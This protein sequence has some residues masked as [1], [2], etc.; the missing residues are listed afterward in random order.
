[1]GLSI[2]ER[3]VARVRSCANAHLHRRLV[4]RLTP[5]QRERLDGLV[6]VPD[7]TRQSPLDRLRD[8]P[9][10]QSGAEIGRA[11]ARLDEIRALTAGLPQVDR[12][13]PGKVA[14]L[15]S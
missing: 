6:V 5:E 1:M 14:A 9:Y 7:G 4:E 12:L 11:L 3:T 8:G 2:L 15:G 10:I 13:P